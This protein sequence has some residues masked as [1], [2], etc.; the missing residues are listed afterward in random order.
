MVLGAS[1]TAGLWNK[2]RTLPL[3]NSL[4]QYLQSPAVAQDLEYQ[5]FDLERRKLEATLGYPATVGEFMSGVFKNAL[6]YAT[7]AA[8][9]EKVPSVVFLM[10]AGDRAKAAKLI[11]VLDQ[12]NKDYA[13][14]SAVT[15]SAVAPTTGSLPVA[16]AKPST[17]EKLT[18]GGVSVSHY[19]YRDES[20]A[21]QEGFYTLAGDRL[22]FSNRQAALNRA[23]TG[24]A[25][26]AVP[27]T[28]NADYVRL[29]NS[30]PTRKA[31]L[32][33]W[34]DADYLVRYTPYGGMLKAMPGVAASNKIAWA[35]NVVPDGLFVKAATT[36]DPAKRSPD[37][38][39]GKLEGLAFVAQNPLAAV[40]YGLFDPGMINS[41]LTM[42]KAMPGVMGGPGSSAGDPILRFEQATGVSVQQEL[43][44]ALGGEFT[45]GFNKVDMTN[46]STIGFLPF[47][48]VDLSI[49]VKLKD[50]AKMAAIMIKLEKYMEQKVRSAAGPQAGAMGVADGAAAGGP[51]PQ[52]ALTFQSVQAGGAQ[53]RTLPFSQ[54][55]APSYTILKDYVLIGLN[56]ASV[57]AAVSRAGGQSPSIGASPA[58][59]ELAR[60][61]G[62]NPALYSYSAVDISQIVSLLGTY[63]PMFLNNQTPS[64][65]QQLMGLVNNVLIHSGTLA[66]IETRESD[67][68]VTYTKLTMR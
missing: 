55:F 34:F 33:G 45:F 1:D 37:I 61:A 53:I 46:T 6:F 18:V 57:A 19:I 10:T 27:I 62:N 32:V 11:E 13:A 20:G 24:L 29:T 43:I 40:V 52:A 58:Y 22:L 44:P 47:P 26:G 15:A 4:T 64:A 35:I 25:S 38:K 9:G 56:T 50:P 2:S 16:P 59:L 65:Q 54:G 28:K 14:A 8:A 23:L 12:K 36:A 67:I 63:L 31:D 66:A 49:G 30:L 48:T 21:G 41:E 17:F 7:P 39:P 42:L 68:P 51:D 3:V 60:L 5:A